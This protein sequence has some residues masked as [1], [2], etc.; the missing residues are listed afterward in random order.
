MED[1]G[2]DVSNKIVAGWT[3]AETNHQRDDLER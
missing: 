3:T 2:A 1:V